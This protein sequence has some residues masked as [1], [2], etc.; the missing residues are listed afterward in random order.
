M[1]GISGWERIQAEF[2]N[3]GTIAVSAAET[4]TLAPS[5]SA[6]RI[7]VY[8]GMVTVQSAAGGNPPVLMTLAIGGTVQ[9]LQWFE[10]LT[11]GSPAGGHGRAN[12]LCIPSGTYLQGELGDSVTFSV[13]NYDGVNTLSGVKTTLFYQEEAA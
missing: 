10:S 3:M 11:G 1:A 12:K 9:I 4:L 8:G 2:L 6:H 13:E 7:L 5:S